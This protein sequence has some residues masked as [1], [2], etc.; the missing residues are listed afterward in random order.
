MGLPWDFHPLSGERIHLDLLRDDDL[1]PLYALQSDPEVCRYL[2]YEPRSREQV[3]DVL[4]RDAAATRLESPGDYLQPAIRDAD[5]R[6]CGTMYFELHSAEPDRTAEIGWILLP[7]AQGRGYAWEAAALLLDLAFGEL[8]L[9]RVYAELDPRN[10][11]S[12]A[13][14]LSL[15]MR[16]EGRFAEHM[17]LKGE[18]TD[19]GHY[20]ILEREWRAA[21][22]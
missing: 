10:D 6:F 16:L 11:A 22:G 4:R 7:Q 1:E 3:A 14:C 13:L 8:A 20:A 12:V 2:L 17:W 19:T 15:G 9:H 18:W 21:R 5:G